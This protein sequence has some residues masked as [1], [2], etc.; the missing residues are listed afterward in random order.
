MTS[1]I[2]QQWN[3]ETYWRDLINCSHP[4]ELR[5]LSLQDPQSLFLFSL[6]QIALHS[7]F[8][9]ISAL[10]PSMHAELQKKPSSESS[11]SGPYSEEEKDSV[12]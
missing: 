6:D 5:T 3:N 1:Q 4:S 9:S 7:C 12:E 11:S 10:I 8:T 2:I